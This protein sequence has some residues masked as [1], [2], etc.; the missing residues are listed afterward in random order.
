MPDDKTEVVV[1][2]PTPDLTQDQ[3]VV[4]VPEVKKEAP[5]KK[6]DE[7]DISRLKCLEGQTNAYKRVW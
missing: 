1:E 4:D 6:L 7:E 3:V 5:A 2:N